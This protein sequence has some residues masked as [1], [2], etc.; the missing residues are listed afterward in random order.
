MLTRQGGHSGSPTPGWPQAGL[1]VLLLVAWLSPGSPPLSQGK[2]TQPSQ[3]SSEV[4]TVCEAHSLA[5]AH[6]SPNGG[7]LSSGA[8][9]GPPPHLSANPTS[10]P[11][12]E[13]SPPALPSPLLKA[14][15]QTIHGNAQGADQNADSWP[16]PTEPGPG[17]QPR[18]QHYRTTQMGVSEPQPEHEQGSGLGAHFW[19]WWEAEEWTGLRGLGSLYGSPRGPLRQ[20]PTNKS[21]FLPAPQGENLA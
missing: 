4:G 9:P 19:A 2:Q 1:P 21:F 7:H 3:Q 10:L 11:V 15:P 6:A 17:E 8:S 14:W 18:H 16:C 5:Q 12:E 20:K 13:P